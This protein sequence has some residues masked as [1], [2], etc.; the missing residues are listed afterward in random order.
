[1]TSRVIIFDRDGIALAEIEG[2]VE[3]DWILNETSACT[4]IHSTQT[5]SKLN[6]KI[7]APGNRVLVQSNDVQ[8][9]AGVMWYPWAWKQS[10]LKVAALGA[11]LYLARRNINSK[12]PTGMDLA[13]A[14]QHLLEN[15]RGAPV[16]MSGRDNV[17][18]SIAGELSDNTITEE[19]TILQ[20][21]DALADSFYAEWWLEPRYSNQRLEW[22]LY[23]HQNR[24]YEGIDIV[25]GGEQSACFLN[26]DNMMSISGDLVT[27]VKA[28]IQ[29]GA[30]TIPR[31]SFDNA[32][33]AKHGLWEASVS[34]E[35]TS[36]AQV[37]A[38]ITAWLLENALPKVRYNVRIIPERN[39]KLSKSLRPGSWHNFIAPDVGFF[40]GGVGT[41]D[42]VRVVGMSYNDADGFIDVVAE[43][44]LGI[45][46]T[47]W[48]EQLRVRI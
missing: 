25:I 36:M 35:Y 40:Q 34:F 16:F 48:L 15:A 23:F 32:A 29:A 20:G 47:E 3:R 22:E 31:E 24:Q 17:A 18:G 11:E 2:D 4:I 44:R 9:W 39:R 12:P 28:K 21:L 27:F 5:T 38:Q 33:I 43:Q 8:D 13:G 42:V 30:N 19:M 10:E 46:L 41:R 26:P 14:L 6:N 45:E 37:D 7:F 1:M